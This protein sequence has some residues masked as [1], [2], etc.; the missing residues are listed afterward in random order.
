MKSQAPRL[1]P[2]DIYFVICIWGVWYTIEPWEAAK[3]KSNDFV[4]SLAYLPSYPTDGEPASSTP[5]L[6]FQLHF[7]SK[8][9]LEPLRVMFL[10]P[11]EGVVPQNILKFATAASKGAKGGDLAELKW[12]MLQVHITNV[13]IYIYIYIYATYV[14]FL[15]TA[16]FMLHSH[17]ITLPLR[18]TA[19]AKV[20]AWRRMPM[21]GSSI[22]P[23]NTCTSPQKTGARLPQ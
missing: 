7:P 1:P 9:P 3:N 16:C 19:R 6:Q 13:Y 21:I 12:N 17:I 10:V 5:P 23:T 18:L 8:Y 4:L 20:T 11:H 14:L 15:C 2:P 22:T